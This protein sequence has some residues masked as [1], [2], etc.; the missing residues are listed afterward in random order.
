M[1]HFWTQK[2]AGL[3]KGI[4]HAKSSRM[5]ELM[6]ISVEKEELATN[7]AQRVSVPS[8]IVLLICV[9]LS[10]H[11]SHDSDENV[12]PFLQPRV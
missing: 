3:N 10:V 8:E 12:D 7:V 5:H 9:P 6:I 1:L 4:I 2:S 11:L